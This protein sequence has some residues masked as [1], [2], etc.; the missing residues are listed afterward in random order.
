M[1]PYRTAD[2]KQPGPDYALDGGFSLRFQ[3]PLRCPVCDAPPVSVASQRSRTGAQTWGTEWTHSATFECGNTVKIVTKKSKTGDCQVEHVVQ[4]EPCSALRGPMPDVAVISCTECLVDGRRRPGPK[5]TGSWDGSGFNVLPSW[6]RDP[7]PFACGGGEDRSG[8][9]LARLR[10]LSEA[11]HDEE[12]PPWCPLRDG[13]VLVRRAGHP[14][15][16]GSAVGLRAE[17]EKLRRALVLECQTS[18]FLRARLRDV[19]NELACRKQ[20]T[21]ASCG[22]GTQRRDD[23]EIFE[24]YCALKPEGQQDCAPTHYCGDWEPKEK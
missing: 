11:E 13:P 3:L 18:H 9:M 6:S 14:M 22:H 7:C 10:D 1:D 12:C 4:D 17:L 20:Q 24:V 21:C 23:G 5:P 19:A 8:C 15:A 2:A 16:P